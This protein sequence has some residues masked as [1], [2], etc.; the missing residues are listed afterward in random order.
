MEQQ[1]PIK[2]QMLETLTEKLKADYKHLMV[3]HNAS[4]R[5]P[6]DREEARL[7]LARSTKEAKSMVQQLEGTNDPALRGLYGQL[8]IQMTLSED[9]VKHPGT[10][11]R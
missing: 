1:R 11:K 4:W 8:L 10:L 3:L 9:A 6:E 2:P 5:T 7:A